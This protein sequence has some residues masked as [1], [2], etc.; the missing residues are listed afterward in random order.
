M[1]REKFKQAAQEF[2]FTF[3]VAF[4]LS[5]AGYVSGWTKLPNLGEVSS[6]FA[7]ALTAASVALGKAVT[8]YFTGTKA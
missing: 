5:F 1:D 8:W 4:V 7:A 6:A 3:G 2:A